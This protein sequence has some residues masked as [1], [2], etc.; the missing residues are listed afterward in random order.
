MHHKSLRAL[1]NI[2]GGLPASQMP[3]A[4]QTLARIAP[5]LFVAQR[6]RRFTA[7]RKDGLRNR[8]FF[9]KIK[10]PVPI[11]TPSAAT[12]AI[13]CVVQHPVDHGGGVFA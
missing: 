7:R 6:V 3:G 1:I 2:H 11:H 5:H 12:G 13:V 9:V 10:N 4:T 8:T